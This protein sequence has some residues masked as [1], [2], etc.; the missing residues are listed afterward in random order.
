MAWE[1]QGHIFDPREHKA[2][3]GSH[4]QV[5][6]VLVKDNVFRIYYADRHEDNRSFPTYLDVD[7]GNPSRVV[8]YH[9]KPILLYGK[10][11]TFD[12]DGIMPASVL[13]HEGKVYMYYSGWNRGVSV[14]YRNAT[15][16]ATSTDGGDTFARVFEGP[17]LERNP[18][19]PYVAVTPWVMK[20][21]SFWR[22]WYISG[23]SWEEI[24]GT[25]EPVYVIK[26][27]E[28]ADGMHWNR[29]NII[30]VP[31]KHDLEAF[32]HPCVVVRN[33]M[34]CMWYSYRCSHD[35]RDG[36]GS[37]RMG[38]AE[39][40]DGVRFARRD[41]QA[42]ITVSP[43]GWD[44]TMICY[45]YVVEADGKMYLFYNGNGFGKTGIGYALWKR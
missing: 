36:K 45:P 42:G 12:D 19:E 44:S 37:Y 4:A 1:K 2:W 29:P 38:Y 30:S 24:D 11:G 40:K 39:S 3:A 22:A 25:L 7:R 6:A 8:Y 34:Y 27:A 5:P 35:Y 41:E 26:Y 17:I 14:P 18:E 28:S 33:G 32:S 21:K 15:G 43:E 10:P 9:K 31:Q 13:E 20:E 16:L 23:L